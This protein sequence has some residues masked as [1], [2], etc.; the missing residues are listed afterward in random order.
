MRK[1]KSEDS[2]VVRDE[3]NMIILNG[4]WRLEKRKISAVFVTRCATYRRYPISIGIFFFIIFGIS[5]SVEYFIIGVIFILIACF[6][7]TRYSLRIKMGTGE[8]RPLTSIHRS[9][10]EDIR[11]DIEKA[12]ND[13]KY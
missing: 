7:R 8:I 5:H 12:L 9:E 4:Q 2:R 6:I 10:L 1:D 3:N 13:V 11:R